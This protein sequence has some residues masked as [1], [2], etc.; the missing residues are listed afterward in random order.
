MVLLVLLVVGIGGIFADIVGRGE[1]EIGGCC[2]AS[3][4]R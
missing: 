1:T 3:S 2:E 4:E